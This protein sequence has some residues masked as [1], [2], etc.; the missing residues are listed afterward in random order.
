M[1]AQGEDRVTL[2]FLED[3]KVGAQ[4]PFPFR[5]RIQYS[6]SGAALTQV[7]VVENLGEE[8]MYFALGGHPGFRTPLD[9]GKKRGDYEIVFSRALK[10]ERMEVAENLHQNRCLPYLKSEDRLALDDARVPDSGMFLE[11][12]GVRWIGVA[13]RG[14]AP[15]LKLELGDFPNVNMWTPTGMPFVC[16]E[17]M[18]GHHDVI[19]ASYEIS[20]KDCVISLGRGETRLFRFTMRVNE[21]V[22]GP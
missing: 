17:P 13:R 6:L 11:D 22:E 12:V 21:T 14:E 1:V 7:F 3:R 9:D 5:F 15:Y 18:I 8:T 4:Y 16:I 19:D 2:E 10:R 20:E